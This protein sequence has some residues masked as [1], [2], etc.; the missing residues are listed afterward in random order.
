MSDFEESNEVLDARGYAEYLI[1][2]A[3]EDLDWDHIAE[4]HPSGANLT[5]DGCNKVAVAIGS[6]RITITWEEVPDVH[7]IDTVRGEA[8]Q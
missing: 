3:S 1:R 4:G 7:T 6:A 5:Q 2:R 8:T